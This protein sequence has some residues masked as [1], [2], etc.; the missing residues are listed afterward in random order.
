MAA[1]SCGIEGNF[2][3]PMPCCTVLW[4]KGELCQANAMLKSK[5]EEEEDEQPEDNEVL[6][7]IFEEEKIL[8]CE[9]GLTQLKAS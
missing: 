7:S 6:R 5:G 2:T 1:L 3:K 4:Y 8:L 9:S